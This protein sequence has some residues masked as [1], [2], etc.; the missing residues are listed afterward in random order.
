[1]GLRFDRTL[2]VIRLVRW[3][4]RE[5]ALMFRL[6]LLQIGQSISSTNVRNL[7]PSLEAVR[8]H[9]SFLPRLLPM[10]ATE[11]RS[12]R[13]GE[14]PKL[15]K[16][17]LLAKAPAGRISLNVVLSAACFLGG[18][19][20]ARLTAPDNAPTI[21]FNIS[22]AEAATFAPEGLAPLAWASQ[23]AANQETSP[24]PAPISEANTPKPVGAS[25]T[26]PRPLDSDEVREAQAWL[27]AFGFY[28][29][30]VDGVSGP[31]TTAAAKRYRL[32]RKM[33]E[34]GG[35][36]RSILKQVRQQSGH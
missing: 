16:L 33:D 26:D 22:R 8:T 1:M 18:Y 30:P 14:N 27:K 11:R 32:A 24:T 28:H 31:L 15:G 25:T 10:S 21:D 3:N 9:A 13:Q 17:P 35:L 34:T 6:N 23:V 2:G 12:A 36:D 19:F 20:T 4:V 5:S 7:T 29:G